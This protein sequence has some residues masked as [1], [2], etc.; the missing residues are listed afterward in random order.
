MEYKKVRTINDIKAD[1]RIENVIMNYDGKSHY[2]ECK[3]G[4]KF[5]GE[6]TIDIGRVGELCYC[7]NNCLEKTED[8]K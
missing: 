8:A 5:E 7:I 6:R 3:D 4:Y 1:P 2:V